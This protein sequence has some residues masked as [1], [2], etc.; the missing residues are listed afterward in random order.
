MPIGGLGKLN[1]P[2]AIHK[3]G[4]AK[5]KSSF[6]DDKDAVDVESNPQQSAVSTESSISNSCL[7][8]L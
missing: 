4:A 7:A 1:P 5:L 8:C 2:L 6:V 3:N